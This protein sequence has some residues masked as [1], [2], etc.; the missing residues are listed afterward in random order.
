MMMI[1]PVIV[2]V[3]RAVVAAFLLFLEARFFWR[4]RLGTLDD[5]IGREEIGATHDETTDRLA[6]LGMLRQ[7]L[8][9]DVLPEF[10]ALRFTFCGDRLVNVRGHGGKR[11]GLI[12]QQ[13]RP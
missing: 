11:V 5:E 7:R 3:P 13:G 10:E 12:L 2:V 4:R 9:R 8:R 1:I 6:G